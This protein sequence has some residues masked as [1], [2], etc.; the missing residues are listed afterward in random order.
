MNK[1]LAKP[2]GLSPQGEAAHA[3]IIAYLESL[4]LTHTGGCKA[5]YSPSEWRERG[6]T[7]GTEAELVIVHDGGD[8]AH[9]CN[10]DYCNEPLREGLREALEKVGLFVEQCTC[11]Y[12]AVY[13]I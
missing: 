10:W 2:E 9:C 5:F 4:D 1:D 13:R 11:W 3:T 7:Y 8:L 12:S 6:E